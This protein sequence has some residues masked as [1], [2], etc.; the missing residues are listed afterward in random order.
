M[1]TGK[2]MLLL[3]RSAGVQTVSGQT[4]LILYYIINKCH[5]TECALFSELEHLPPKHVRSQLWLYASIVSWIVITTLH[6]WL[7][8]L[9]H[10]PAT[11]IIMCKFSSC[12]ICFQLWSMSVA[13]SWNTKTEMRTDLWLNDRICK[14]RL[15]RASSL[16]RRHFD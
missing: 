16:P 11:L 15:K 5:F 1:R 13:W 4:Q 14:Q 7:Q 9:M 10:L 6:S 12:K 8:L 3:C 2:R